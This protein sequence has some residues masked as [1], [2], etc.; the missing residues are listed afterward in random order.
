MPVTP[1]PAPTPAPTMEAPSSVVAPAAPAPIA[2]PVPAPVVTP[3]PAPAPPPPPPPATA[4]IE[5]IL[6]ASGSMETL[7]DGISQLEIAKKAI[8]ESMGSIPAGTNVALRVYAHRVPKADKAGSCQDS[9]LVIPFGPVNSAAV[10]SA[11]QPLK[12]NGY[13]PIAFSLRESAKDFLGKES[14]HVIILLSDGEETCGGDP[15]AEAKNLLAQGF[16]LTIHTIGFRADDNT[17]AQLSALSNATGGSYFDAK[18]ASSLTANLKEA[19]QKALLIEKP[20]ENIRGGEIRGGNQYTDAVLLPTGAEYRLDHHQKKDN[21]DYFYVDLKRDQQMTVTMTTMDQ[22]LDIPDIGQPKETDW[23]HA[24][25]RIMDA[26]FTQIG[27][28]GMSG[29]HERREKAIIADKDARFYILIGC[30]SDAMHKDSPFQINLKNYFDAGA[31]MD[32][33]EDVLHALPINPGDY[34]ENWIPVREDKDAYQ[35]NVKTGEVYTLIFTPQSMKLQ[36][37]ATLYDQDRVELYSG[38]AENEGAV[39]RIENVVPKKDGPL[40]LVVGGGTWEPAQYSMSIQKQGDAL[41]P[42]ASAQT[43]PV[44]SAPPCSTAELDQAKLTIQTLQAQL[45]ALQAQNTESPEARP[46]THDSKINFVIYAL[47][48]LLALMAVVGAALFFLLKK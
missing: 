48:G 1:A 5:F 43:M 4:D 8:G 36:L 21:Y 44:P 18:D 37:D 12:P 14:Q 42:T 45:Q 46:A 39:L 3:T 23:P 30:Q 28:M 10:I 35:M 27:D 41:T 47:L 16:K 6:D 2:A 25:L 34:A 33:G 9:Q 32:A 24:C 22:G 29:R 13:T 31:G 11:I 26:Q 15:V 40:F 20:K 7:V 17:R 38:R 19:T